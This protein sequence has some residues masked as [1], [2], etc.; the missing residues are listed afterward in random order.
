MAFWNKKKMFDI[1]KTFFI[2]NNAT[3][4]ITNN[5]LSFE[6]HFDKNGYSLFPYIKINEDEGIINFTINVREINKNELTFKNLNDLNEFNLKSIY[7]KAFVNN[8]NILYL[9]YN[10]FANI[11]NITNVL[12]EV[13]DSLFSLSDEINE[14]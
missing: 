7:F 13:I 9:E 12:Q 8:D 14:L 11:D 2:T 1:I 5:E 4:S 10:T 3:Y 6:I